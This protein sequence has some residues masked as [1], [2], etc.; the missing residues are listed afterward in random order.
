MPEPKSLLG[1][2]KEMRETWARQKTD[3]AYAFD[4]PVPTRGDALLESTQCRADDGLINSIGDL[5]P[6][7]SE[8]T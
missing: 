1:A 3:S 8:L 4:R 6:R 2:W 7:G 5:A